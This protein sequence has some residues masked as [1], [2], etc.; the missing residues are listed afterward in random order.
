M[1]VYKMNVLED[2]NYI[3]NFQ[4][5]KIY[6]KCKTYRDENNKKINKQNVKLVDTESH[7]YKLIFYNKKNTRQHRLLY[8]K[9]HNV[10]IPDDKYIDHINGIR[11]DNRIVNLRVVTHQLNLQNRGKQQNNTSEYKNI[12]HRKDNNQYQV[13]I[14]CKFYGYFK[15]IEEAIIKRDLVI[16]ELNNNG[17]I[18]KI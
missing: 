11:D 10:K 5:G 1:N 7:G 2:E 8:E 14:G 18:Y 3:F 12:H 17:C 4:E 15:T 6:R 13:Y 16:E 9:Y